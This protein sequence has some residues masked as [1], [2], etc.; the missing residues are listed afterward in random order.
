MREG[1]RFEPTLGDVGLAALADA[2]RALV[3]AGE[4]V[5]D[6]LQLVAIAVGQDEVDLAIT[7][8][9]REVVGV[10][11]L[12]LGLV[13]PLVKLVLHVLQELRPHGLEG[14]AGLLEECFSHT[15][16]RNLGG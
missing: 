4:R 14:F 5:V 13:A 15:G 8:I 6:R 9:A 2:V 7:C 11:P 10:H 12:V 16:R 1:E 3:D